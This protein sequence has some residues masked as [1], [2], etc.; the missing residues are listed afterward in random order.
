MPVWAAFLATVAAGFASGLGGV[1]LSIRHDRAERRRD[2]LLAAA[3]DFSLSFAEALVRTRQTMDVIQ[4][5]KVEAEQIAAAYDTASAQRDIALTRSSRLDL[6]FGPLTPVTVPAVQALQHL[7]ESINALTPP[8]T[9]VKA[10]TQAH[11]LAARRYQDFQ[12][13]AVKEIQLSA[14]P[15]ATLPESLRAWR[16]RHPPKAR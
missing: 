9:D 1:L 12:D 16:A 11:L 8:H 5:Q 2:R 7:A 15:T 14:P 10:A 4:G 13:A 6:L 3:D